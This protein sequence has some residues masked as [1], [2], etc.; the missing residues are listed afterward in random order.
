RKSGSGASTSNQCRTESPGRSIEP[1]R[2]KR[3]NRDSI[4]RRIGRR[5]NGLEKIMNNTHRENG[6]MA[7]PLIFTVPAWWPAHRYDPQ[8]LDLRTDSK[9]IV[10]RD[11]GTNRK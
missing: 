11:T 1:C 7:G 5:L 4:H 9:K 6:T 2:I 10:V 3:S 8:N